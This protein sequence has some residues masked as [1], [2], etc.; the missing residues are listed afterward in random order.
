MQPD[1]TFYSYVRCLACKG[2]VSG[3]DDGTFRPSVPVTRGQ[4]AKIVSNSAGFNEAVSGQTFEDV[5]PGSTFYEFIERLAGR[6]IIG[7]YQCGIVDDEP[8][9]P[10]EN[11]LYFRPD[12]TATR[13]QLTKIV[14]TAAGF[15]DEVSDTE[16]TFADITPGSTWHVYVERLLM[17]RP[18]VM[19]GYPCG[20]PGEDCDTQERPYF[21]PNNTLTR[22][23]TAKIVANTFFPGCNPPA[24]P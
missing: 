4:L 6:S 10:P 24:K 15:N 11:R 18:G 22:G 3:Y 9:V 14:A 16:Y 7:G 19:G 17:N 21:R 2:I 20:D 8:C 1:N 23:Q 13:G 5:P 12:A